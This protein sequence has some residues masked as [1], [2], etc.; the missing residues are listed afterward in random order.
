MEKITIY[1][2]HLLHFLFKHFFPFFILCL[3]YPFALQCAFAFVKMYKESHVWLN[4][5]FIRAKSISKFIWSSI[6]STKKSWP[7]VMFW[8]L[9]STHRILCSEGKILQH[10]Q[11][12]R[13]TYT[14]THEHAGYIKSEQLD[15]FQ[16]EMKDTNFPRIW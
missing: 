9:L 11:A 5:R 3:H 15:Q 13:Y 12:H 14:Y 1:S 16:I 4:S 6:T 10:S 2:I 8:H 7:G